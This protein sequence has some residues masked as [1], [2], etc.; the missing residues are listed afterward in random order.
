VTT[1]QTLASATRHSVDGP[2]QPTSYAS[3]KRETHLAPG[4]TPSWVRLADVF[5]LAGSLGFIGAVLALHGLRA[6]LNPV[7]HTISEYSLGSYGWLMRGAFLALGLGA[8]A[9]AVSLRARFERTFLQRTG[10]LLLALTAI[11]LFLDAGYNTDRPRVPETADGTVH[12]VGMLIICLTL[13]AASFMLGS[14]LM[15]ALGAEPRA[16]WLQVLGVAQ[17]ISILGFKIGPL[18]WHGL[19]ERVAIAFALTTLILLRSLALSPPD[20]QV[21][22]ERSDPELEATEPHLGGLPVR[23]LRRGDNA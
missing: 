3:P 10:L 12:G 23:N 17:L 15:R 11:G 16:R 5:S 20:G 6:S 19:T 4:R 1:P 8:L 18:A 2:T 14:D 9:T 21:K 13:P 22:D 7:D